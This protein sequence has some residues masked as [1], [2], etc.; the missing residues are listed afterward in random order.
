MAEVDINYLIPDL[1]LQLGDLNPAQY[2]YTDVWLTS[3]LFASVKTLERWWNFKYIINPTT[4]FI[5]RNPNTVFI[6]PEPPV[7]E[8]A[9]ERAIILMASIIIKEGS[10]ENASWNVVSWKDN[11]ISFSNLEY[12]R[13]KDKMIDRDWKELESLL[14][15]PTKKLARSLKG[16]L[17]GYKGNNYERNTNY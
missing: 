14:T 4:N 8:H 17:P 1:R 3:A 5:Y 16:D 15:P 6:A 2:R 7:I 9:D 10:L 13:L 12:G 11:E